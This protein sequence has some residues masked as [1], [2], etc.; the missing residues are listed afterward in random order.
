[1]N[2]QPNISVHPYGSLSEMSAPKLSI[3]MPCLNEVKT[4]GVCISKAQSFI[5]RTGIDGEIIIADNG[6]TD[7]SIEIA[8]NAGAMV[9][10][11][12]DRGYGAAL[13]AGF[14]AANGTYVV[15]GDSD[16][17][18]DFENLD[19]FI[20]ELDE[21]A[22][23]VIGNRFAGGIEPGAMP[24][25]HK[26]LGN[27]VLSFLGRSLFPSP[28][29][30]F[31]CGLRAFKREKILQLGLVS[32]GMEFAS[33]M[34]VR[35]TLAKHKIVEVPTILRKDGRG[36]PP[37]LRSFRDG[38][39]HLRFLLLHSPNWLFLYPGLLLLLAGW[40][41]QVS[42]SVNSVRLGSLT[43]G[44]HTLLFSGAASIVGLQLIVYAALAHLAAHRNRWLPSIPPWVTFISKH[45]LERALIAGFA[46]TLI[47]VLLAAVAFL[48]WAQTDFSG[49]EPDNIM[50]IAIPSVTF[51]ISGVEVAFA[52]FL[53][54]LLK[55]EK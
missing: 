46:M 17:S 51:M 38:W 37:H 11:V 30:D 54:H 49:L 36:R 14:R 8:K 53:I 6:S 9:V 41:G 21:G 34:I 45:S 32:P 10:N 39:R 2:H 42:L 18:Y 4:L 27:P 23:M 5:R 16:D 19:N 44:I 29:R 55:T 48:S 26:Y 40:A 50:R 7:G 33:E 31:H 20:Y 25:H 28:V 47:G 43:F 52:S 15:M 3:V 22:D 24:W 12:T 35:S 1:M 13:M